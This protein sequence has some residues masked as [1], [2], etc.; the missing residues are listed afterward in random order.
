MPRKVQSYSQALV[1]L[2][3]LKGQEPFFLD[4]NWQAV[5]DVTKMLTPATRRILA[6]A[7]PSWSTVGNSL[8]TVVPVGEVWII[9]T[10]TASVVGSTVG[11]QLRTSVTFSPNSG[12]TLIVEQGELVTTVS[13]TETVRAVWKPAGTFVAIGG[14]RVGAR[15]EA[16]S[17]TSPPLAANLSI[18]YTPFGPGVT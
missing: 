3:Q 14:D 6:T 9:E 2:L 15:L 17:A 16:I 1:S 5:L 7:T 11:D 8:T 10:V 13:A 18:L 4:E 12:S